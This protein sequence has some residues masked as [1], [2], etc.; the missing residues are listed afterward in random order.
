MPNFVETVAV[1]L[2]ICKTYLEY[3][4]V[5]WSETVEY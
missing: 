4:F 2:E 3:G 1:N 5:F